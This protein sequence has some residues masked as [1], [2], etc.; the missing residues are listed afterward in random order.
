M[1]K[2]LR[3]HDMMLTYPCHKTY[4]SMAKYLRIH[5]IIL[6]MEAWLRMILVVKNRHLLYR[7]GS[8]IPNGY[9]FVSFVGVWA[10][11]LA[12]YHTKV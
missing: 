9:P 3:I 8:L 7:Y 5:V 10:C 4:L 1:A 2:Y 11:F 12:C 6:N